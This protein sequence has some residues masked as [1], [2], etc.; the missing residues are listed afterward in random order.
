[1]KKV[2]MVAESI[3]SPLGSTSKANFDKLRQGISGIALVDDPKLSPG[4]FYVG[5]IPDPPQRF[6]SDQIRD[7]SQHGDLERN[8]PGIF[9]G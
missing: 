1:M 8:G 2:W 5:A 6:L 9:T 7:R 3:V 4:P